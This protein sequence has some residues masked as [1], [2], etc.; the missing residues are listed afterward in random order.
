MWTL[1]PH[2]LVLGIYIHRNYSTLLIEILSS[3]SSSAVAIHFRFFFSFSFC[4]FRKR[5]YVALLNVYDIGGV[6]KFAFNVHRPRK[7]Y[8]NL[9]IAEIIALLTS[10]AALHKNTLNRRWRHWRQR[11]WKEESSVLNTTG[12]VICQHTMQW[13]ARP[14]RGEAEQREWGNIGHHNIII[15]HTYS[16]TFFA[17]E[18]H[19][20]GVCE[21]LI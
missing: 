1:V 17:I 15:F 2:F 19:H 8:I 21:S 16:H 10:V 18:V 3:Y 13:K 11:K 14:T 20:Q 12:P 9:T 5:V 4:D 7:Y 6:L